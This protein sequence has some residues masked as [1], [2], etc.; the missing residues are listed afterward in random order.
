VLPLTREVID[1]AFWRAMQLSAMLV[2]LVFVGV[3]A[4]RRVRPR[5]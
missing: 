1:H 2:A 3:F 4:L 5:A